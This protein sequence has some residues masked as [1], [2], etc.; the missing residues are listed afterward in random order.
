MNELL[1]K[2]IDLLV[3]NY[4]LIKKEF[5]FEDMHM[6]RFVAMH[7]TLSNKKID[8]DS[9]KNT[10]EFL[11]DETRIGSVFRSTTKFYISALLNESDTQDLLLENCVNIYSLLKDAGFDRSSHLALCA[12]QIAKDSNPLEYANV[13]ERFKEIYEGLKYFHKIIIGDDDLICCTLLA[14][15]NKQVGDIVSNV[16]L[17]YRSLKDEYS[18][19]NGCLLLAQILVLLDK[20][21]TDVKA[22]VD[23]ST[24]LKSAGIKI[25]RANTLSTLG[26]LSVIPVAELELVHELANAKKY[27]KSQ[28]GF[29]ALS[30]TNDELTICLTSLVAMTFTPNSDQISPFVVSNILNIMLMNQFVMIAIIATTAT[31]S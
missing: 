4:G 29:S 17:L 15:S 20:G 6:K 30:V 11:K 25:E 23:L 16:E 5:L 1:V 3:E 7:Y 12:Y 21:P 24:E 27:L 31:A 19:S 14:L 2:N 22:L 18:S 26:L 8:V 28:K 10:L 9:L 13:V